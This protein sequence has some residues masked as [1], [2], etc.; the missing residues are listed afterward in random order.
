MKFVLSTI[1]GVESIAKKEIEKQGGKIEEVI[2]RLVTFSGEKELIAN[3]NYWSRVGN[4]LYLLMGEADNITDFDSLFDLVKSINWKQIFKKDFPIVVKSSSIRSELFSARTIQSIGKKAI[5]NSLVGD[6][7]VVNE[8]ENLQKAEIFILLIDNKARIL[9]N[10]SGN[11][12]HMRGY[13]TQAG[14]APIKESLAAALVL[15]SNW[16][17]K[18]N[19]YDTFCGSGTIAIEALM[20]AKN[21]APGLKRAFAFEKLGLLDWETSENLRALARKKIFDGD[22]T[23]MGSD[24]DPEMVELAKENAARAGLAGEINFERKDFKEYLDKELHGT[25]VSNPP[26]GERLKEEDLRGMYNNIDKLFRLNP[27]LGGGVIS[28]YMEF[29]SLIKKDTYKKRKLYNG[30]EKC[31]FWRRK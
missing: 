29:D 4:K 15:L 21:I 31:Y 11:A 23:I 24:I 16:R 14:D 17:F 12:L 8:D 26:Y 1:A 25:L 7:G 20:I 10:T 3:V 28:S 5:V 9:L 27:K 30:G 18:E 22:Y 13:R 2:D 19:F 6:I